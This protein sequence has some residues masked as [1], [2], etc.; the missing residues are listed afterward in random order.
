MRYDAD[1][2]LLARG[3]SLVTVNVIYF[4]PDYS[5]LLNEFMW[6]T[7]DLSPK[8]PRIQKFLTYWR[9]SIDATVKEVLLADSQ[10]FNP[11]KFRRVD[12]LFTIQ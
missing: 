3:Y 2:E 11:G 7:L 6:Q 8:Y 4:I 9:K 5:G 1:F 10:G 12:G